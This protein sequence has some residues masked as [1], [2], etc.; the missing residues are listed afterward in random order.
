MR[1]NGGPRLV[2]LTESLSRSSEAVYG[3]EGHDLVHGFSRA[4]CPR[5]RASVGLAA[6]VS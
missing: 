3:T 5:C 1:M 4:D 6:T 2:T